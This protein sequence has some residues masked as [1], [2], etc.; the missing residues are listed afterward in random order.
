MVSVH[1]PCHIHFKYR[2]MI[3]KIDHIRLTYHN[4]ANCSICFAVSMQP[5]LTASVFLIYLYFPYF[6]MSLHNITTHFALQVMTTS[7]ILRQ[8]M[9]VLSTMVHT[10]HIA[11]HCD[12]YS[13]SK[14]VGTEVVG[15]TMQSCHL[16]TLER[17][18]FKGS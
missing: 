5:I 1:E 10:N 3:Q 4:H 12:N 7:F 11:S 17:V 18:H 2:H 14:V 15:V 8:V 9:L 6:V 16:H 13:I